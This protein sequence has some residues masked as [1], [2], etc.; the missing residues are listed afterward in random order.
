MD[1]SEG[2]GWFFFSLCPSNFIKT[3][4]CTSKTNF[5]IAPI[6]PFYS[7]TIWASAQ[8]LISFVIFIFRCWLGFAL[9]MKIGKPLILAMPSPFGLISTMSTSYSSPMSNG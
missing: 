8:P 6:R 2:S 1:A 3:V 4:F 9:L 5:P 7:G